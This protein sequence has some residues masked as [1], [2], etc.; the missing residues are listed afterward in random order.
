MY[1][2]GAVFHTATVL[3]IH[4]RACPH[5]DAMAMKGWVTPADPS[6]APAGSSSLKVPHAP[7]QLLADIS[8]DLCKAGLVPAGPLPALKPKA[9]A[10]RKTRYGG[11]V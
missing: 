7:E 8:A 1:C 5:V 4:L 6:K 9:A 11:Y 2:A 3:D 10:K